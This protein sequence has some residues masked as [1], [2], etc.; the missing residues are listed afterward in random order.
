MGSV[1][2]SGLRLAACG[3]VLGLAVAVPGA[4]VVASR[5]HGFS[6]VSVPALCLSSALVMFAA[7]AAAAHPARRVLRIQPGQ[8][9]RSE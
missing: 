7:V 3:L 2:A 4:L 5:M 9:V 1:L 8:I 6:P